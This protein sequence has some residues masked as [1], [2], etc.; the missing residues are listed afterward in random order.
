MFIA[1]QAGGRKDPRFPDIPNMLEF[2]KTPE[3]TKALQFVFSPLDLGRP[4]AAPPETPADRLTILRKAFDATMKDKE[5]LEDATRVKIDIEAM[6]GP[7]TAGVVNRLFA[8]PKAVI[9]RV[10]AALATGAK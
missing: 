9:D 10:S 1:A 3:D 6:D 7:T 4:I 2:A 5:F 8:T